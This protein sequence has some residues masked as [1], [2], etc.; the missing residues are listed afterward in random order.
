MPETK[1]STT[2]FGYREV[3]LQ[4]K[5]ELVRGVFSSVAGKYDVMNDLMSL[6]VHRLWKWDFIANSGIR[7]GHHLLD[8][9]GGT[10]DIAALASKRVGER[11][12]LSSVTSMPTCWGS[13]VNDL[14]TRAF[15]ATLNTRWSTPSNCR[16]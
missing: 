4:E 6:G 11:G 1:P 7:T 2:H 13:A 8:L 15:A 3:A 10:G 16:L 5:T 14:K 9:A 12:R